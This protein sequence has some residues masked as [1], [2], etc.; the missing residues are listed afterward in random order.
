VRRGDLLRHHHAPGVDDQ[1]GHLVLAQRGHPGDDPLVALVGQPR[2]DEDVRPAGDHR[3]S[4]L[5]GEAEA[6]HRLIR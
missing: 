6:D 1:L 4:F 2:H 3:L 5:L